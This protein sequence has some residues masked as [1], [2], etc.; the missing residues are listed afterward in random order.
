MIVVRQRMIKTNQR[1][2]PLGSALLF[3]A[4]L[5]L[6]SCNPTEVTPTGSRSGIL[7]NKDGSYDNMG[8]VYEESPAI[9]GGAAVSAS[10]INMAPYVYRKYPKAITSNTILTGNCGMNFYFYGNYSDS[11][12]NCI[13]SLGNHT[14]FQ[15]LPRQA[16]NTWM[17]PTG[18]KE[19]Y[20]VNAL[21]H[22]QKGVDTFF[23]KMAYA[24]KKIHS[25]PLAVP[26]SVPS[27]LRSSN[28]FWFTGVS[29]LDSQI[30]RNSFLSSY[31]QCEAANNASFDPAGPSLCFGYHPS[32][33]NFFFVQDPSIIYH[34]FGHAMVSIMMNMR[35][36]TATETHPF[37]SNLGKFGFDEAGSLN[38]GIADYYSYVMNK[39]THI[40]EWA[41]GLYNQSRPMSESDSAH[42]PAL[43]TTSEGRLSYP[44][45]I[46]YDPNN[47]NIPI[48]DV[49]YGGQIVSHYMVALTEEFK[50]QCGISGDADGGHAAATSYMVLLLSETLSE[51]GDLNAKGIDDFT[52]PFTD[53]TYF[54]NLDPTN[55]FLWTQYVNKVTYRRFFQV[56]AK[57]IYKYITGSV[58][59]GFDKNESEKLL[60]DYGLL[61]FKNYNDN[62]NSTKSRTLAYTNAVPFIPA[63]ALTPVSENNRRKS[64]L[65]SKT[66]LNSATAV[67]NSSSTVGFYIIDNRTD[68]QNL[69]ADLLYKG[70]PVPL[71]TGTAGVDYNNG[72]I[73]VSPGEIVAVIPNLYNSSNSTMA[74]VH[75]LANDWDHVNV[76]DRTTG[77]FK[78]CVVDTVTTVDQGAEAALTCTT[79][80][81]DY[82]R[83][84]KN[85]STNL[86]PANAAAPV[87]MVQ[88][89]SGNSTRW[90]SQNEFRRKQ[91]LTLQDKDCLGYST[92]GV[93]ETDFSFNPHECLA[94]FLPGA[95]DAFFSKINPSKTY[96]ETVV[97]DSD[98]KHFNAGNLLIMEVNKWVPPGTKFRC[99][100]RAK[101]GNCSDCYTD[102]ANANDDYQDSE[103]NGPKPYKVINF[104]F[105]VND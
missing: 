62:G 93:S 17:Y 19:F 1:H 10:S 46:N 59:S 91:G 14:D 97:K 79:T 68:M 6:S 23:E 15:S 63:Q 98:S 60:D 71:S 82:K 21:Y 96:Y 57:N 104:D 70:F 40:G 33:P 94:R 49:H 88:L 5:A 65:V 90:V 26:K 84:V 18:S 54:N 42:V 37:R 43:D 103:Y 36:G 28:M 92:T 77:N 12:D 13:Q 29:S 83:L 41:L 55:S 51:L 48:E 58:C 38:E 64:V 72:N 86:F 24:Y 102:A 89:E 69:L 22:V 32:Y 85:T 75:L 8:Y 27:Y 9:L 31:S 76:T 78:P 74:G 56:F 105:D 20:Q 7:S 66:L 44:Q 52:I 73:K 34:E 11:L 101:F 4:L 99:R 3:A 50:S 95:S 81:T 2:L 30:F 45:Y 53:A 35:N 39:R 61:L 25:L 100:L 67:A 47:P 80:E 16:E 87:C